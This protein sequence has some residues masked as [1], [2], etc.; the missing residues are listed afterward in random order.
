MEEAA[1]KFFSMDRGMLQLIQRVAAEGCAV[2]AMELAILL[3]IK[4][5]AYQE[6]GHGIQVQ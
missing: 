6:V 5:L 4:L 3:P 2:N 1:Q